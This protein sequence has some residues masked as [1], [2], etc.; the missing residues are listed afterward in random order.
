MSAGILLP[1][2]RSFAHKVVASGICM[3]IIQRGY[4]FA[5]PAELAVILS[6]RCREF[7]QPQIDEGVPRHDCQSLH[8]LLLKLCAVIRGLKNES[9]DVQPSGL[10]PF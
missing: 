3:R 5:Y 7:S 8:G 6:D 10:S 2:V 1:N 4:G 9:L